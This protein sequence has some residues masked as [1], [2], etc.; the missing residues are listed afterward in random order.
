MS[1]VADCDTVFA[2]PFAATVH[3]VS[4]D[5]NVI[6]PLPSIVAVPLFGTKIYVFEEL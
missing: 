4:D 2:P 1:E 6:T 3:S 5:D